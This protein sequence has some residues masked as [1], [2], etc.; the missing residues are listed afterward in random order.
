MGGKGYLKKNMSNKE[1]VKR[2]LILMCS[3]LGVALLTMIY[4]YTWLNVLPGH[5][6]WKINLFFKGHILLIVVY[7]ALL[8]FF[9]SVLGGLRVGYLK[10]MDV[11]LSHVFALIIVNIVSYAQISLMELRLFKAS[12]II[13]MT[14]IQIVFAG[15]WTIFSN[16]LY[17]IFFPP[18]RL[19]FVHG[20]RPVDD[21]VAKFATRKDKYI[22]ANKINV[23][24]PEEELREEMLKKDYDGVVLWDL[25]AKL[26]NRNLKFLYAHNVRVY[27]SPKISDVIIKG[28]DPLHLF[29]TP[30]F[31]TR[32][33]SLKV[34][35]RFFKRII[36]IV[37]A[38]ILMVITSP[39][40]LITA[41]IIKCYDG[42]PV[43]YKQVRCTQGAR[44]FKIMKFRSMRVDAE[45]DGVA[46]LATKN[47]SR[48]TPIGRFI[49]AV[50]IDELPQLFNILKGDMSFIGPRPERPEII[51]QYMEEMPEF[52][53]RMKVKAGL[54]G[55]AQVYGKYNTTPYDKLK[56]D[57]SYIEN[58]SVWLDIKLMLLTLKI[59]VTPEATEGVDENQTTAAKG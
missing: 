13:V 49:R 41:I 20:D 39:V 55:Y 44:E 31:L 54:A 47:D 2:T 56:L 23:N 14:V 10:P 46:R 35:Q 15:I 40:M 12:P 33:Y 19:L 3:M 24:M 7:G 51:R 11:F 58:Y 34:E 29:D 4:G 57:L 37:C 18:R 6:V 52:A 21:I 26:R 22:I 17:H 50:R 25:P 38:L 45:K 43:L 32:E 28:S 1:T 27:M 8:F 16:Y 53:F 5:Y 42:G 9:T 36:D 59:L 48:I 30:I